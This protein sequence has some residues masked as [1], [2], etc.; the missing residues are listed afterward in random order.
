MEKEELVRALASESSQCS[1]LKVI[2]RLKSTCHLIMQWITA[3]FE[4][5]VL[6]MKGDL[7]NLLGDAHTI[8]IYS[9]ILRKEML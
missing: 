6:N 5:E 4:Y 1:R 2:F 3:S 8:D 9:S 7:Y